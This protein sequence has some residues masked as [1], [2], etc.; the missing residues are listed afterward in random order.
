MAMVDGDWTIQR[1]T[2]N[3]RYIGDDHGGASPSYAT[4]IQFHRWLQDFADQEVSAGDDELDITDLTPSERSTDNIITL[5]N[6]FNITATEAEHLYDG[7]IIQG[8]GGTEEYYDG[9]VNYGNADVQIQIIQNGAVLSDDWWNYAGG[10]L[11]ADAE[12]GISHRF[13]IQTR[14]AGA[15]ID[16]RRL[17]GT[18]RQFNKTYSEFKINGTA[19]GNN[20]LA[21][22]NTDDLNNETVEATVSG[23]TTITNLVEGYN[24]MDVDNNGSSEYYYSK[25]D[26]DTSNYSINDFYERMKWLTRDGSASTLYGLNGELFRGITHEIPVDGASGTMCEVEP[27]TWNTG[28]GQMFATNSTTAASKIWIQLL[29]GTAP[30]D[31]AVIT[32]D[33]SSNSVTTN[34]AFVERPL[35]TPFVGQ[36]TGSAI[37]GSYGL[38]IDNNDLTAADKVFDL[39]NNQITPPNNVTFTVFGLYTA[40]DRVLVTNDQSGGIDYD[41]M[42][43][44][45]SLTTATESVVDVGSGNIPADTPS[46]GIIRVQ[47]DDGRYVR[48]G[49]SSYN[50]THFTLN[51]TYDFLTANGDNATAG[52]NVFIGYIDKLATTNNET[53]TTVYDADRTLFIRVRDGGGSPIKTFE[54]TGTLGSTGGSATAIRTSDA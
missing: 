35:S 30:V 45:T 4:V 38:G 37:I 25:W 8:S 18:T 16:G 11:N 42:T 9:I 48:C 13:M 44:Q 36:S 47:V 40:E 17:I 41:Q 14:T 33:T 27:V 32:G 43:L 26:V 20:V 29:T 22:T 7:S 10:G 34:G 6:G 50:D 54:T 49:Y 1:S 19:R 12:A 23:W 51:T 28:T 39:T 5:K 24:G 15:D 21:L 3:I 53:F 31:N 52:N 46:T 2:G